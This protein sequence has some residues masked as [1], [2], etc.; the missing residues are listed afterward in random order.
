MLAIVGLVTVLLVLISILTKKIIDNV[1]VDC[2]TNYRLFSFRIRRRN[3][4]IY[5]GGD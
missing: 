5:D 2:S 1:C 4:K 3:G